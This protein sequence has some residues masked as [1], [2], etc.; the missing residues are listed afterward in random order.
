M[1]LNNITLTVIRRTPAADPWSTGDYDPGAEATHTVALA[2][3][4]PL[5]DKD[6]ANLPERLQASA[7]HKLIIPASADLRLGG[8]DASE[9]PDLILFEGQRYRL[10]SLRKWPSFLI[11]HAKYAMVLPESLEMRPDGAGS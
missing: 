8:E 11:K 6:L 3:V 2:D 5:S 10:V 1:F 4:Q 7:K 9:P